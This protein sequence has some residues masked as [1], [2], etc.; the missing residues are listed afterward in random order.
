MSR[1][2]RKKLGSGYFHIIVQGNNKDYVFYEGWLKKKYI[3]YLKNYSQ[4]MNIKLL[5]YCIM[6]SHAHVLVYTNK[7]EDLSRMM[8][9]V[10]TKYAILFNKKNN[11]CGHV[12]RDRFKSEKIINLRH[13]ENCIRYIHRNPVNANMCK[14]E[15]DYRYSS[16]NDYLNHKISDEIIQLAYGND[17]NYMTKVKSKV[18]D[19]DFS[20]FIDAE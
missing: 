12:Y 2:I 8:C 15:S 5:S 10:N 16:Y 19:E 17:P 6:D 3:E 9:Q 1:I 4:K 11:R 7:N 20:L 14:K 18:M 13:L